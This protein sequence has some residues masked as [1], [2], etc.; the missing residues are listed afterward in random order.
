MHHRVLF[1]GSEQRVAPEFVVLRE[2]PYELQT[3]AKESPGDVARR[4]LADL[5]LN[6]SFSSRGSAD[7]GNLVIHRDRAIGSYRVTYDGVAGSLKVERQ[8]F[9]LAFFLEMLHR[10]GG[11]GESFLANDLWA[12]LVDV[13]IVAIALWAGTGIW[14]WWG[15]PRTRILGGLC[16]IG[17][18]TLFLFLLFIL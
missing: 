13:V 15:L 5:G 4:I 17:G 9:G 2:G 8:R 10:R 14:M 1:T 12:I 18:S 11:L 6:G 7:G 3:D 16:L